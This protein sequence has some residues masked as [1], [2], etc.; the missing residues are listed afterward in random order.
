[1]NTLI[2]NDK[3]FPDLPKELK[4]GY[5]SKEHLTKL[6]ATRC[7]LPVSALVL[8]VELAT[9]VTA[10]DQG[11]ISRLDCMIDCPTQIIISYDPDAKR[12][13]YNGGGY[14]VISAFYLL[15]IKDGKTYNLS[16]VYSS[17]ELLLIFNTARRNITRLQE[18]PNGGESDIDVLVE[19]VTTFNL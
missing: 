5:P 7:V 16:K 1:M 14:N 19:A 18:R 2:E 10:S 11:S 17:D 9:E 3:L 6:R 4:R 15:V 12:V 8:A 13:P